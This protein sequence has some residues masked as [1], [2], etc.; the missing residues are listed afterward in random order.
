MVKDG[1]N[2]GG[3]RVR[4]GPGLPDL[5]THRRAHRDSWVGSLRA[6]REPIPG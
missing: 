1:T 6:G 4:T 5:P 2:R 3:R